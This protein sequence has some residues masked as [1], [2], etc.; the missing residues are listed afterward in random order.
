MK[1]QSSQAKFEANRANAK[2]STGPKSD[3][4][5]ANSRQNATKHGAYATAVLL[6][7]EDEALYTLIKAEQNKKYKPATFVEKAL[8]TQLIGELWNLRRITKAEHFFALDVQ[9]RFAERGV[10]LASLPQD[11]REKRALQSREASPSNFAEQVERGKDLER[12]ERRSEEL[13]KDE[14]R[15]LGIWRAYRKIEEKDSKIPDAYLEIFLYAR[16]EQMQKLTWLRR[17]CLQAILA[18]E[19][20]LDRRLRSRKKSKEGN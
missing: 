11:D 10:D 2:K 5:K 3:R 16:Q 7:G 18:L 14:K 4:G 13:D 12:T 1:K 6:R 9:N 8:V 17:H 15:A 20:E 19:R